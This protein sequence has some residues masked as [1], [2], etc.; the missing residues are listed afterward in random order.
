MFIQSL[1]I[2]VIG[3]LAMD[4][5]ALILNK[6]FNVHTTNW[7]MVGR[8]FGH[9]PR[10]VFI[11]LPI[12]ESE[13]VACEK[14]IGWGMHYAIGIFYG[15]LYLY[16]ILELMSST[17]TF[18]SALTFALATLIAPWFILQPGLGVGVLARKAPQPYALRLISVSMHT[19]FG[20]G[21]YL[22]C[23]MLSI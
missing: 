11:H 1:I 15:L 13:P 14:L 7:G 23:Y 8:W 19:V 6:G 16:I 20:C 21:L 9:M 10:G 18:L 22:G 17:P 4:V 2:G 5:W 12:T 3:T